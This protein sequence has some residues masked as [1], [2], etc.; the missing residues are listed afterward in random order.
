MLPNGTLST[1]PVVSAFQAPRQQVRASAV[2][3]LTDYHFGGVALGNASLGL[4]YQVWTAFC[5]DGLNVWM[6]SPNTPAFVLLAGVAPV[7]LALSFD[8]NSRPFVGY[9]TAVG[10]AFFYWFNTLF[11]QFVTT[12]LPTT[13]IYQRIFASID[14]L[15]PQN[16]TASDTL[17][18]YVRT[19]TL[20]MRQQRDRYTVEYT[21]GAAPGRQ[22]QAYMNI[23]WRYQ[24]AF[25]NTN[26]DQ[27]LPPQ[28]YTLPPGVNPP[29]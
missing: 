3:G 12:Q 4:S 29:S 20:F 24:F 21:L 1:S 14:D 6:Q 25:L 5:P 19:G 23:D 27:Y 2:D 18:S 7:W 13:D 28:E 8:Q 9:V 17:L 22:I 10:T 16:I 26:G 15:R 11:N